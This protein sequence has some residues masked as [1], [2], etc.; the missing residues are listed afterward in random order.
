V[1]LVV[2]ARSLTAGPETAATVARLVGSGVTEVLAE[3][4]LLHWKLAF[5]VARADRA[6]RSSC[7]GTAVTVDTAVTV[8]TASTA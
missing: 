6:D 5:Q 8:P 2:M 4:A 3:T 1:V 7:S